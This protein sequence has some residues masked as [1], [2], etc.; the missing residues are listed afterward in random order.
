MM[1]RAPARFGGIMTATQL[2]GLA[3]LRVA[4][5]DRQTQ[6]LGE[7]LFDRKPERLAERWGAWWEEW[8]G[9]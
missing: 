1:A 2:A 4:R 7:T 9:G 3:R 6:R 5:L 8:R